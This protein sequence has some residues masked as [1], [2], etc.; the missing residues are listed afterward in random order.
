MLGNICSWFSAAKPSLGCSSM[1]IAIL[2]VRT[3]VHRQKFSQ[4][5][6]LILN[7]DKNN[8][9]RPLLAYFHCPKFHLLG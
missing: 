6:Y 3:L 5:K 4:Q 8:L 1:Y 9:N 7:T 2:I